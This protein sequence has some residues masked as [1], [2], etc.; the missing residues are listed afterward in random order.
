MMASTISRVGFRL[1][2][3]C[4]C[5]IGKARTNPS[6][7]QNHLVALSEPAHNLRH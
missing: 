4:F 2:R 5:E 3:L 7:L 6:L 1:Y